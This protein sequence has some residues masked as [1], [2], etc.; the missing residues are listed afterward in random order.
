[1]RGSN[2]HRSGCKGS[3]GYGRRSTVDVRK[4][5]KTHRGGSVVGMRSG[6]AG[7]HV[8]GRTSDVREGPTGSFCT[9]VAF[10]G[11]ES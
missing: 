4:L 11:P 6:A 3:T 2:R 8:V 9:M 1:M 5:W 7:V 10:C